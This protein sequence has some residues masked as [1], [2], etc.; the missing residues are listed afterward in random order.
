MK[1]AVL[2]IFVLETFAS[3]SEGKG[4]TVIENDMNYI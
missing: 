1:F 2:V 4:S 3:G